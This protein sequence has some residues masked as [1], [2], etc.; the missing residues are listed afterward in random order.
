MDA[1]REPDAA[2][3][4]SQETVESWD[5]LDDPAIASCLLLTERPV[6]RVFALNPFRL[7]RRLIIQQ[8]L[9]LI[10]GDI[11]LPFVENL[12]QSYGRDDAMVR[13]HMRKIVL[14]PDRKERSH[15]LR[16][17]RSMNIMTEVLFPDLS[18]FAR[19]LVNRLAYADVY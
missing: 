2:T 5:K 18:S 3:W 14:K 9:F 8:A 17:L 7:N 11:R 1:D 15:I 19:S 4:H 10:S 12:R 6:P 13:R 16:E